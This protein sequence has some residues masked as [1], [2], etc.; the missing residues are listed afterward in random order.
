ML[1]SS[2][3]SL[4]GT[5][6][7]VMG[8]KVERVTQNLSPR[9][10]WHILT[11]ILILN[12]ALMIGIALYLAYSIRFRLDIPIFRLDAFS[13][14][15]Y[16]QNLSLILIPIWIII[17]A[18]NGLYNRKILLG[19][20]EEYSLVFRATS[21]GILA[22]IIVSFLIPDFVLSRAWLLLA[23]LFTLLLAGTGRLIVRRFAYELRRHGYFLEPTII[24]GA[25]QEGRA[26]AQQLISWQTSGMHVV[27]FVDDSVQSGS[28]VYAYLDCLG[29]TNQL[30]QLIDEHKIGELVLANSAL[31]REEMLRIFK[32]YG[33]ADG[34]NLRLS[35]GLFEVI[36]TGLD[37]KEFAYVPLVRVRKA[38]LTGFDRA[39]KLML[40]YAVIIPSLIFLSPLLLVIAIAIKRDSPGPIIHRRRVMGINGSQFDA[41]K[42]RTMCTNGD[43][44][45]AQH[46]ELQQE[47]DRTY[48]LKEDPRIT[49]LGRFLRKT[50]LDELPQLFNVLKR[51]MSL[52]GP[53]IISPPEMDEYGDWGM[54]LLTVPPGITGLWQVSGRSDV[55]YEERVRL[56][57]H[58]IRNWT[59]W[60]DLQI[61]WR[62]I[63]AV[64]A[65]HGAY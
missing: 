41:Y 39:F 3:N 65:G 5:A 20:T 61:L 29:S 7:G 50:S 47:L 19:G 37:V 32:K 43:E 9:T 35:S 36:T 60:F 63:P 24:V 53:R 64:L 23:W 44:I 15:D 12:D 40:D 26:L 56:D 2:T 31:S 14:Y 59:I 58:Y 22:V 28:E 18:A 46:P 30:D 16:Y 49:K 27:G 17:F 54:N 45:L 8:M 62:T 1:Q 11:S 4:E 10:Q 55:S 42:F 51:E 38:R 6:E 33:M 34:I 21:M 25:N 57:M 13:I 48:K 52:V